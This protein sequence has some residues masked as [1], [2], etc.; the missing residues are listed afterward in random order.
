[1]KFET[2]RSRPS[3][4]RRAL[5]WFIAGILLAGIGLP[6]SAFAESGLRAGP[7][8]GE[9][10]AIPAGN[11]TEVVQVV[12]SDSPAYSPASFT[13]NVSSN[14]SVELF[15]NGSLAHTFTVSPL[16]NYVL[17]Q[18]WTPLQLD[19][20]Y[21]TEGAL[22]NVNVSAGQHAWANLTLNASTSPGAYE[23][24]SL[25]PYQFQAGMS[26]RI[27]VQGG[28]GL[29]LSENTTD[30][31]SF[32]PNILDLTPS[33]YPVTVDVLVTNLGNDGHTFTMSP[34]SNVTLLPSNFT[35]FFQ[36]HSPLTNAPIPS[37]AGNAAWAN[38]TVYGPGVYQYICTITGHFANGMYGFLYVGVPIP[39][40]PPPLSTAIVQGWILV[41]VAALLGVG[42]A[43][44]IMASL[45]GR[46]PP[47]PK[48]PEGPH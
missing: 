37:G 46:M 45:T 31:L 34:L 20:F 28:P 24:Y 26:G 43:V 25:I 33:A 22:A 5:P 10:H 40:P 30:S 6:G 17:P 8:I 35:Q 27:L 42:I 29:E 21:A 1:M 32:V 19:H 48:A 15:N 41:G 23:V 13:A 12:M 36:Q 4:L 7:L 3:P 18:N 38:F 9:G 44:V 16:P 11:R 14:L 39:P 47:P 2:T